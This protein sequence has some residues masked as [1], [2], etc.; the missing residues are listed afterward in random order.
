[1]QRNVFASNKARVQYRSCPRSVKP[2]RSD[3]YL[4][5]R[6]VV[7]SMAPLVTVWPYRTLA[8]ATL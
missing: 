1:M 7:T 3:R 8:S 5:L 6:R 2:P 4:Y